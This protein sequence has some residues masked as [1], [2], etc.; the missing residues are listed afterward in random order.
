M[1]E[2]FDLIGDLYKGMNDGL[3]STAVSVGGAIGLTIV[4]AIVGV[5]GAYAIE[6]I[7]V[8][9]CCVT[10]VP[11]ICISVYWKGFWGDVGYSLKW[12]WICGL[13]IGFD[14][15]FLV[16]LPMWLIFF[17]AVVGGSLSLVCIAGGA[18]LAVPF[19][20][21]FG[22]CFLV[23]AIC[24]YSYENCG[25]SVCDCCNYICGCI[26]LCTSGCC[27]CLSDC[28]GIIGGSCQLMCFS[29]KETCASCTCKSIKAKSKTKSSPKT[30]PDPPKDNGTLPK[31]TK[32]TIVFDSTIYEPKDNKTLPKITENTIIF[33]S[34]I[35]DKQSNNKKWFN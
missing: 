18:A 2:L 9:G 7:A 12:M 33:D 6:L 14:I 32:D 29:C 27:S 13:C 35:Y 23:Y 26:K 25:S 4:F 22:I 8:A 1:S 5:L 34:T 15:G 17:V 11:I 30:K 10:I 19:G 3:D 31:I 20:I 16:F 21:L 28:F 24:V